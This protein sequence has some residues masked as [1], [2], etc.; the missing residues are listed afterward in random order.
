MT[1]VCATSRKETRNNS[2]DNDGVLMWSTIYF[3]DDQG[4][5]L[6]M[7]EYDGEGNLIQSYL[8]EG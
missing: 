8:N 7:E 4:N 5:Y 3:Y 2:Y 1:W 6:G